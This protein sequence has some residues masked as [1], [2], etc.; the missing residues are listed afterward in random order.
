MTAQPHKQTSHG[1]RPT[2]SS[3]FK[4]TRSAEPIDDLRR[5]AGFQHHGAK[6]SLDHALC[7][8]VSNHVAKLALRDLLRNLQLLQTHP[9]EREH[10]GHEEA[11][12]LH[13][14]PKAP[15]HSSCCRQARRVPRHPTAR[16]AIT[17]DHDRVLE[18][19]EP[20]AAEHL[21]HSL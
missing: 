21:D 15:V 9:L 17:I 6:D 8:C 4:C 13:G 19:I 20:F 1:D 2:T 18:G 12:A 5:Q 7:E 11:P 14:Q 10:L 16:R 3:H